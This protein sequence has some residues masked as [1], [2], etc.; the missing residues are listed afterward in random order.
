MV[1]QEAEDIIHHLV[2]VTRKGGEL[3]LQVPC[4]GGELDLQVLCEGRGLDLCL[5]VV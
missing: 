5:V 1:L 2:Q 4:E 3:D